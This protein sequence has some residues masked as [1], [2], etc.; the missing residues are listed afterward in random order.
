MRMPKFLPGFLVLYSATFLFVL[1]LLC[2]K[3]PHSLYFSKG[4]STA[5]VERL[6]NLDLQRLAA[7]EYHFK[8][9]VT[10]ETNPQNSKHTDITRPHIA[11]TIITVKRKSKKYQP[12]Y[13]TQCLHHFMKIVKEMKEIG[14]HWELSVCNVDSNPLKYE[15]AQNLSKYV[16]VFQPYVK[17]RSTA[18]NLFEKEKR[19]Y[20]YCLNK[21]LNLHPEFAFVI[22]DDALPHPDFSRVFPDIV[23]RLMDN[24]S[25][26]VSFNKDKIAYV[27]FYHPE[28]LLG[29]FNP[30]PN[31]IPELLI[32]GFILGAVTVWIC[33]VVKLH[34]VGKNTHS[35]WL[36]FSVYFMLCMIAIGRVNVL[37]LRRLS[38]HFY[39]IVPAP[40]CC[41]PA[42]LFPQKG[43]HEIVNFLSKV[44]C[45]NKYAMDTALDDFMRKSEV[46]PYYVEPNLFQHIGLYSSL[47]LK[48][49]DPFI[50]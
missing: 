30:E 35:L 32:M 40:T 49:L 16:T 33:Q 43:G 28:R 45:K 4:S 3:L 1:P 25:H 26:S 29:Y 44:E 13:L 39:N 42:M 6:K 2:W 19:D 34:I 48:V 38:H 21:T 5:E 7:A 22:E 46:R 50:V 12:H 15:E 17:K 23:N 10:G 18:G 37:E 9:Q 24:K 36:I 41:T 14:Q 20:V 8:E 31:R 27:K 11:V 47:R